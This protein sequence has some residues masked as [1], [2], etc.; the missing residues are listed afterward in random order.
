[1]N[2]LAAQTSRH[3]FPS[4]PVRRTSREPERKRRR[5]MSMT[6]FLRP[7]A[8]HDRKHA[9]RHARILALTGML[10]LAVAGCA[11]VH[12]AGP[13]RVVAADATGPAPSHP[14]TKNL[15]PH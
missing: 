10:T 3:A 15:P 2:R 11:V 14:A 9:K 13:A 1:M 5:P 6:S 12:A 4:R 7:P 8:P